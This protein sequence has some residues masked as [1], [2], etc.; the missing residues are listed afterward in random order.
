M[1]T[2][3]IRLGTRKIAENKRRREEM[4]AR[5]RQRIIRQREREV[6]EQMHARR[7]ARLIAEYNELYRPSRH[8]E[9]VVYNNPKL[10]EK[11]KS[12]QDKWLNDVGY[13]LFNISPYHQRVGQRHYSEQYHPTLEQKIEAS[14]RGQ[15]WPTANKAWCRKH[16]GCYGPD[17]RSMA[18]AIFE[19][20]FH[21]R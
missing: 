3:K 12:D 9:E 17:K 16:S 10:L 2:P 18:E 19:T 7:H 14:R 8:L 21:R 4:A 20:H 11:L 1:E 5:E 13:R 6:M 15:P